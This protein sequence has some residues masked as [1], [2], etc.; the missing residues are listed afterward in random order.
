VQR[1]VLPLVGSAVLLMLGGALMGAGYGSLV[2]DPAQTS[3]L[4]LAALG[5]WPAVLVYTGL[6][7]AL[8]GWLPRLSVPLTWGVLGATYV[9]VLVGEALHLPGWLL[10][11]LP[12]S[13]TPYLPFEPVSWVALAVLTVVGAG[14]LTAGVAR[15]AR[16]DVQPG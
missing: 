7:V 8:V 10:D 6:A 14:L 2:D 3:R 15:F 5:Y 4:A 11:L 1:L 16:R 9:V 13:A 12:F